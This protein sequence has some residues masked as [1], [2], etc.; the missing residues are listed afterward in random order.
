MS[1]EEQGRGGK[2]SKASKRG[3]K[4]IVPERELVQR[5]KTKNK[6]R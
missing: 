1:E 4:F 5:W 2:E 3:R 6:K